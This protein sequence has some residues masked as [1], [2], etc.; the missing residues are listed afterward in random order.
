MNDYVFIEEYFAHSINEA[1]DIIGLVV[2][3]YE[4]N[5]ST[6]KVLYMKRS[7]SNRYFPRKKILSGTVIFTLS[8]I[9]TRWNNPY[10]KMTPITIKE[11]KRKV[12]FD[13][14]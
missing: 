3:K 13:V 1:F 2:K 9:Q 8:Y 6:I 4:N 12:F 14:L 10:K 11:I 7:L 5:D